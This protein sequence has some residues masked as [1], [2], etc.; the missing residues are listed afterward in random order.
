MDRTALLLFAAL[1]TGC[2]SADA[3][4]A[5]AAPEP[6]Y[7]IDTAA[8]PSPPAGSRLGNILASLHVRVCVRADVPPFGYFHQ[9]GLGGFDVALAN[10]IVDQ[11]SI[12]YKQALQPSWVVVAA[13]DRVKR[14][15]DDACDLMI[16]AFSYSKERAG[17][18]ATSRVYTRSDKVLIAASKITRKTAVIGKL[19][20]TTG[21]ASIP[22]TVRTFR[23]YQEI[24]HALDAG[25]IDY[26]AADRPIAEHLL[27][28]TG[29]PYVVTKTLATN[30]E[31]Y[32]AAVRNGDPLLLA[33]VDRALDTIART[34]RLALLE[35][36]WL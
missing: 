18:V 34:G 33:A 19:E 15:Q 32:V 1:V 16:G 29:K 24:T 9:G 11:L 5:K 10:E 17:Q 23:T 28:S 6:L 30:A 12:D 8:Q 14:L 13:G 4:P 36:R 25:E 7:E 27:R 22:G 35:R 3:Q 31:S 21:D 2:A 26:L 20:G